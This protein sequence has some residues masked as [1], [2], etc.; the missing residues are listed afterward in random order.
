[1]TR[2]GLNTEHNQ[3]VDGQTEGPSEDRQTVPELSEF[4][5]EDMSEYRQ[6]HVGLSESPEIQQTEQAEQAEQTL[7]EQS[8]KPTSDLLPVNSRLGVL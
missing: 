2:S 1:M 8:D 5:L 6:A 3:A 4:D 7:P